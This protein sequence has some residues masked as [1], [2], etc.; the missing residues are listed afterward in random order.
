MRSDAL[1]GDHRTVLVSSGSHKSL[2]GALGTSPASVA[3]AEPPP[4]PILTDPLTEGENTPCQPVS[5]T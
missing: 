4:F 5:V 2:G 1:L 3:L